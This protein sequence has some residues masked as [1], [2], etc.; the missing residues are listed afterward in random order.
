MEQNNTQSTWNNLLHFFGI[1]NDCQC[2]SLFGL[3]ILMINVLGI[4]YLNWVDELQLSLNKIHLLYFLYF[5]KNYPSNEFTCCS[6]FGV[7][8]KTFHKY[9]YA[10]LGLLYKKLDL[11]CII[12][13]F[14][15][16]I[17]L[18]FLYYMFKLF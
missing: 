5:A 18:K 4:L 11:V 15:K 7:D 9:C 14:L 6:F 8:Q 12:L 17:F 10:V 1:T 16:I 13:S 3:S 2:S